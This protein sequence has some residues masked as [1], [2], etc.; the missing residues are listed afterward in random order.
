MATSDRGINARVERYRTELETRGDDPR[1][2]T[3]AQFH[4]AVQAAQQAVT[5][6]S[7]SDDLTEFLDNL[8]AKGL[9]RAT[10][11][12]T[13][14]V[15]PW[16]IALKAI[17][18][19]EAEARN[20]IPDDQDLRTLMAAAYQDS[21]EFGLLVDVRKETGARFLATTLGSLSCQAC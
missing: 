5:A 20:V 14:N 8:V 15:R 19:A 21:D 6:S 16:K 18:S 2:A 1:N 17:G 13:T 9:K 4:L 11:D 10:I 3:R 7:L 12:R